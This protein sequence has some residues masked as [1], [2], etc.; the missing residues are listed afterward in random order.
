MDPRATDPN[1]EML[2]HTLA[3]LAYR[4]VKTL[5]GAPGGFPEFRVSESSRTPA[6][7]LAH[8]GDLLDWALSLSKGKEEWHDSPP[9]PWEEEIR[10]FHAALQALD[11]RLASD[12]PLGAPA[13]RLFQGPIADAL[14]HVG[15]IAML[16]RAAGAPI[17]GEN[18][19]R[20]RIATGRVG[21]SQ[22]S[23]V[24]EFE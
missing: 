20:A 10:R 17:R 15:Q 8:M 9:L 14:T 21:P 5:R 1:R 2:R 24:R 22:P 12:L 7:I 6:Q 19:L 3:T 18:Y 4:A 16:R 11:D 23:P 13:E